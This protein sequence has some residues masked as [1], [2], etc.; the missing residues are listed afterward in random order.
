MSSL[1]F[2]GL[3]QAERAAREADRK[4]Y[5]AEKNDIKKFYSDIV[6]AKEDLVKAKE[7]LLALQVQI[8]LKLEAELLAKESELRAVATMRPLIELGCCKYAKTTNST[9]AVQTFVQNELDNQN[10]TQKKWL[11]DT[12]TALEGNA[13]ML[14]DVKREFTD[15]YHELSKKIH[16]PELKIAKGFV[17]GG[18]APLRIATALVLLK[19]Q[20]LKLLSYEI[21]YADE[22]YRPLKQ[23]VGG[24]VI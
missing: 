9:V 6:K 24:V 16:H 8:N 11:T 3:F 21:T 15:L 18:D 22:S 23:L 10:S 19:L 20:D 4:S 12:L 14:S 17:C 5:E 13:M 7:D 2:Q 1:D